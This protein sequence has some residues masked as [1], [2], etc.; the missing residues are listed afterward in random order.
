MRRL[1]VALLLLLPAVPAHA[2]DNDPSVVAR[3]DAVE[4][5]L[6]D[7]V[8]VEVRAGVADQLLLVNPTP[9]P[10]EVVGMDGRPFLRIGANGVEADVAS[11]DWP[12]SNS[13]AGLASTP[14]PGRPAQWRLVSREHSWGWFDHRLH[15]ASNLLTAGVR[16]ARRVVRLADW[17]VPLRQ[18]TTRALARGHVEYRPVLGAFRSRVTAVPDGVHAEALDGRVPGLFVTWRGTGT[19][20]LAGIDGEPFARFSRDGVDVNEASATWQDDQRLRGHSLT[21]VAQG[22]RWRHVSDT[23]SLTW[24]DRRLAY[25]PG[26]PPDDAIDR[27]TTLVEWSVGGIRGETVWVPNAPAKRRDG[28]ALVWLGA[29]AVVAG[30]ALVALRRTQGRR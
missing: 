19:L 2:H 29:A 21:V 27:E 8:V 18:G 4:P 3:L 10:V 25:A 30:A 15:P 5:P 20:T 6:A 11:P 23:P 14:P 13:P 28:H 1:L 7:G 24:L 12:L 17:S 9:T 16:R 26:V 22:P